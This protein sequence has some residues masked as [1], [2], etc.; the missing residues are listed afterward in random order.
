MKIPA[1]TL[2]A[3]VTVALVSAF[4]GTAAAQGPLAEV[5][6]L[7]AAAAYEDALSALGKMDSSKMD[8]S[9][10]ARGE[11]EQFRAFC[12]IALGRTADAERAIEAVVSADPLFV[13]E[14]SDVS[15]RILAMFNDVRRRL[16]PE[17]ARRVYLDGRS[18]FQ[19]KDFA[20]ASRQ[21]DQVMRLIDQAGADN[22]AAMDDLRI[23]VAG[24]VDLTKAAI[25]TPSPR[26][27]N[28]AAAARPDATRSQAAAGPED[29]TGPVIVHQEL[30]PWNP[31]TAAMGGR[32]YSGAV[33]IVIGPDGRVHDAT[34]LKPVHPLY[35]PLVLQAA[36]RWEY[37]P[38]TRLGEPIISEKVVEIRLAPR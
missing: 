5:R 8:S 2:V 3:A 1:R 29:F 32:A 22:A 34:V 33:K 31:P 28:A 20:V 38:A 30:P 36:R 4:T 37:R 24:F 13:P 14:S 17:I 6:A 7:Y 21:F 18:A 35:D 27:S 10:A 25:E 19:A 9:A 11:A 12:L 15:P 16:L 23:L 26:V